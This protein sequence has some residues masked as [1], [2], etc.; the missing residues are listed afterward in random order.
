MLNA[1]IRDRDIIPPER[2][3]DVDF[4]DFMADEMGTAAAVFA[5]VGEP[6]TDD[7]RA[8]MADYLAGH[9]RGRLGRVATSA[10]DVRFRRARPA[11]PIR[12]VH[13]AVLVVAPTSGLSRFV[14]Q[15][16]DICAQ[17]RRIRML[18]DQA[19]RDLIAT[20]HDAE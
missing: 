5:L 14:E 18:A 1:L 10:G 13:R 20:A 17:L 3:I 19:Y 4:D 2:S 6:M 7:A 16:D 9:Q 12:T 15:R 8:A 11:D